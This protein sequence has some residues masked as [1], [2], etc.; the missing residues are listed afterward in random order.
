MFEVLYKAAAENSVDFA[1]G[2]CVFFWGDGDRRVFRHVEPARGRNILDER[3]DLDKNPEYGIADITRIWSAVYR[4][5]FLLEN[6]LWF[7]ETPGASFQDVSFSVLVGLVA[8]SCIY[9]HQQLYYYR[10]DRPGSSVRT[11]GKIM[12]DI[13]EMNYIEKYLET[14]NMYN[15]VHRMLV[16]DIRLDIYEWNVLRLS[17]EEKHLFIDAVKEEMRDYQPCGEYFKSLT[18]RQRVQVDMLTDADTVIRYQ[19]KVRQDGAYINNVVRHGLETGGY[20]VVCA[21]RLY[22]KFA[23]LRSV[24][25]DELIKAVCDN[26]REL[27]GHDKCGL[28]VLGVEEAAFSYKDSEWLILNMRHADDIE[29]QLCSL[30]VGVGHISKMKIWP[31]ISAHAEYITV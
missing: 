17:D 23:E 25:G 15:N 10:M 22:E 29:R 20:V 16:K 9:V 2:G 30:G 31:E 3:L 14:H 4:R 12:C 6:E 5:E 19:E 18:D 28:T 8:R 1:K 21:G 27:Q 24:C 13:D 7:N 11:A 26:N